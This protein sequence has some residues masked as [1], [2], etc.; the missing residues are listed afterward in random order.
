MP[1]TMDGV[2]EARADEYHWYV[3]RVRGTS[4]GLVVVVPAAIARHLGLR[5]G[6][7]VEV[8]IRKADEEAIREHGGVYGIRFL[9]AVRGAPWRRARCPRCGEEGTVTLHRGFVYVRH[10]RRKMCYVCT[11]RAVGERA[12][13]LKGIVERLLRGER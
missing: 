2:K 9:R 11:A 3:A 10:G 13:E 4:A 7:V 5:P 8:A 6:D 1:L 12:P